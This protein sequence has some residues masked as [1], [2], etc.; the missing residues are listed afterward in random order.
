[1]HDRTGEGSIAAGDDSFKAGLIPLLLLVAAYVL[2]F[3]DRQILGVLAV[4]IKADLHL[5]DSELGMVGGIAYALFYTVLAIP[6]ARFADRTSRTRIVV[7]CCAIWSS[8]TALTGLAQN[9]AHLFIARLGLGLG[10]AGFTAPCY[11]LIPD[12]FPPKFRARAFAIFQFGIPIGS[13]LGIFFGGWLAAQLGWRQAFILLGLIGLPVSAILWFVVREPVRGRFDG[14]VQYAKA[15]IPFRLVARRLAATPSYW[16][17]SIGASCSA[18]QMFGLMFWL[19]SLFKRSFGLSLT[20]VS[21]FFGSIVLIGGIGGLWLGASIVDRMG[22][23]RPRAYALVPAGALLAAGPLYVLAVTS[24]N[25][26]LAFVLF[27]VTQA[28]GLFGAAPM[29]AALQQVVHPSIRASSSAIYLLIT[30]I[31]GIAFGTWV[32]GFMSDLMKSHYGDQALKYSILYGQG[33]YLLAS[34]LLF[35]A[36]RH[37]ERDWKKAHEPLV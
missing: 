10:E 19:P 21:N 33:F 32:L 20:E 4:P 15:E 8:F 34:L 30:G 24:S 1:M 27:V 5:S 18:I 14:T 36:S 26:S 12:L 7:I 3:I 31:L 25:H 16:L 23:D 22:P 6:I 2:N 35:W 28:L 9:F 13:A 29:V 11:S 17:V 37:I